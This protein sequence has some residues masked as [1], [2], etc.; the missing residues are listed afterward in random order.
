[1]SSYHDTLQFLYAQ[2]PMYQ[3]EGNSAFK[4]D[5]N[6]IKQLCHLLGHPHLR[7][8][9]I[10]VAGTNGKGSVSHMVASILQCSKR[11]VGLYTSPHYRDFRERIKIDGAYISKGEVVDFV[12]RIQPALT[13]I[14]PSFFEIT[15]AMAF[16]HF[17][18]HN[19]DV[20]VI[21]TGLGGRLD[22]TNIVRPCLSVIT[23]IGL[24][25]QDMLGETLPEIAWE[26]AGIIKPEVPALVGKRNTQTD[27]VFQE[28]AN[29]LNTN[30][31][32]ADEWCQ[33]TLS[34]DQMHS[35]LQVEYAH[36]NPYH[37]TTIKSDLGGPFLAENTRTTLAVVEVLRKLGWSITND[38]MLAGL[39]DVR[40]Q[41]AYQGRWQ[42]LQRAP[43]V[44]A[45]SAHN[46]DG[47]R[48]AMQG[49]QQIPHRTLR[50]VFG[51]VV[52]KDHDSILKLLAN[53]AMYYFC[54]ADQPRAMPPDALADLASSLE[55]RG[56]V[57][58][59]VR[60]A[61]SAA[62]AESDPEDL[63]FVGGSTFVTAEILGQLN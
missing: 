48:L 40:H 6:N 45:D 35:T 44:I 15:V 37:P 56:R 32:F 52:N 58:T 8:E 36:G 17:S 26:K 9:T 41:T 39:L 16:D 7:F 27:P 13:L 28:R 12:E 54:A 47:L 63:I 14:Q 10:H 49:L 62:I 31:T 60:E 19:V 24:D 29:R 33:V 57:Y 25:H 50:I 46:V 43:M 4:K 5:L 34:P 1:M 2:L 20:A 30:L 42:M 53:D 21:E 59:S 38:H 51:M 55:L 3:R 61:L 22:S 11:K 23:N 18:R